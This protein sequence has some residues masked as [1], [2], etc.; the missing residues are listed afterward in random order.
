MANEKQALTLNPQ[1]GPNDPAKLEEYAR[2]HYRMKH[3]S[4]DVYV[5]E[6]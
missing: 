1:G 5:I 3:D 6:K 2:E 4:E